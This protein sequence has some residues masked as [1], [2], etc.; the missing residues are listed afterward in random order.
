M[1]LR[2]KKGDTVKILAG[3]DKGKTGR[4][5]MVYPE[6]LRVLVEGVN[7]K[8]RHTRPSQANPKGGIIAKEAPIH[9]SNVALLDDKNKPTRAGIKIEEQSGKTVKT[10]IARTTGKPI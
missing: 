6:Q 9:Y 3:N 4:V 10:R 2:I 8:K 5:L 1:K 7:I